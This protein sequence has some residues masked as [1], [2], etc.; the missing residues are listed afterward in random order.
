[1][2]AADHALHPPLGG[3]RIRPMPLAADILF[4][5]LRIGTMALPNRIV[6]APM[7]RGFAIEGAM[8]QSHV[9]YYRRR[10]EGGT[11]LVI[12][13]GTVVDRP[14]ARNE[15][16]VPKFHDDALT[17]WQPVVD[18]VHEAGGAMAPQLWHVGSV[19][20]ST[21]K[22]WEPEGPVESPSGL[23]AP[24]LERGEVMSEAGLWSIPS[25]H[26]SRRLLTPSAWGLMRSNC[27]ARMD[28]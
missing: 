22:E 17:S 12:S 3:G 1:M 25:P 15:P 23:I 9:D 16:Y 27:T 6:M 14:A 26:S 11:G 18:A 10:V 4:E 20:S 19:R 7:T 5:P 8:G 24:G 21:N 13:E 28:I 2:E